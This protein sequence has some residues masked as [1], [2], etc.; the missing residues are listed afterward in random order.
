MPAHRQRWSPGS[1]QESFWRSELETSVKLF[2]FRGDAAQW[3][4]PGIQDQKN[5]V[6]ASRNLEL[7]K[8]EALVITEGNGSQTGS[9]KHCTFYCRLWCGRRAKDNSPGTGRGVRSH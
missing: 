4:L 8:I 1:L 3:S 6:Q 2:N 5:R 7:K 9:V